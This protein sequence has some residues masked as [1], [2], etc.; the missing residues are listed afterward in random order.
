MSRF[1]LHET[2]METEGGG[3]PPERTIGAT[4]VLVELPVLKTVWSRGKEDDAVG[5]GL[6]ILKRFQGCASHV[7]C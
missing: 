3:R 6:E 1:R 2:R 7:L 4:T 5:A